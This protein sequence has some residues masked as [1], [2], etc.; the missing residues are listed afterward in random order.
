M[1]W[2]YDWDI[3][4]SPFWKGL[5]AKASCIADSTHR[6][7]RRQPLYEWRTGMDLEDPTQESVLSTALTGA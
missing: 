4:G 2:A 3:L 6:L 1:D 5:I 7:K